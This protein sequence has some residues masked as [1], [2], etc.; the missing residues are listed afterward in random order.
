MTGRAV[1]AD[2]AV[3]KDGSLREF[4]QK[5]HLHHPDKGG[6]LQTFLEL[7]KY[8]PALQSIPSDF[9]CS[10]STWINRALTTSS[11]GQKFNFAILTPILELV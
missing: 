2:T 5:L 9:F 4:R 6:D 7:H 11:A 3:V 1:T 10:V 8:A